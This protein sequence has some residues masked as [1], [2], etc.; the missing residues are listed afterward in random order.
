MR[1][2][3]ADERA[4][5]RERKK[6]ELQRCLEDGGDP[7]EDGA[8]TSAEPIAIEGQGHLRDVVDSHDVVLVDCYAD[9]C[10]PCKMLEP[11]IEALAAE[12]DAA[13]AKVD[14][15]A[16]QRLAQQLGARSVPTLVLYADGDPVERLL[17]AQDR[18]TL[19]SLIERPST[20]ADR[21]T[22]HRK[23]SAR[24]DHR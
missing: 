12:T 2:T 21:V 18:A 23:G 3:A 10:G 5:I 14:V 6:R 4:R 17:G 11:T 1:D 13:V 16:H 20:T 22:I 9:W 15:D 8:A 24:K 19:E 7:S